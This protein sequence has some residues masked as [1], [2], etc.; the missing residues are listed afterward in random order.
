VKLVRPGVEKIVVAEADAVTATSPS[1]AVA[2]RRRPHLA[3]PKIMFFFNA[4]EF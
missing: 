2:A 1:K 3:C 4:F